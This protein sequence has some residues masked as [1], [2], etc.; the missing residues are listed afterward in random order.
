MFEVFH[1]EA[2]FE[3]GDAAVAGALAS[4]I[5]QF[6]T[7]P[8]SSLII[9]LY[10]LNF[11]SIRCSWMLLEPE[12]CSTSTIISTLFNEYNKLQCKKDGEAYFLECIHDL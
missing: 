1:K 6:L 5:A 4:L 10:C 2:K 12:Q 7:T 3:G 11:T 9:A 8:V